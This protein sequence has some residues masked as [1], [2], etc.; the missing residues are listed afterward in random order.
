MVGYVLWGALGTLV[1]LAGSG[2]LVG[3]RLLTAQRRTW[4]RHLTPRL[5]A[6]A[7]YIQSIAPALEAE[8]RRLPNVIV[9]LMDDMG[10]GDIGAFGNRLIKTPRLDE[11]AASGAVMRNGFASSPVCTP[12]RF[13]LLTGRYPH[14]GM[15]NGVFFPSIK[16]R[17]RDHFP[18]G[19]DN[20]G[21][22]AGL[23]SPPKAKNPM[24]AVIRSLIK[25]T[26]TVNA[27]LPDEITLAEALR[28]RGYRTGIFGKW[29]LGDTPGSVPNDKG[30]DYFF[31][32]HYSNDMVPYH[33]WRN[34]TVVEG[35][36]IDQS[37]LTRRLTAEITEFIDRSGDD[38]FFVYYPSPWPHH[39][40]HAGSDFKGRSNAGLYGD[41]IEEIDWSVGTIVDALKDRGKLENT[42]I[43]FTSDNGPWH[44]GSPGGHRGRKGNAFNGGVA[45]PTIAS[46]PSTIPAGRSSDE[47]VMNIDILPTLLA[48]AGID[49]PQDREID[50]RDI[51]PLLVGERTESPHDEL[52]F[53]MDM[54]AQAV[55]DRDRFKY[56]GSGKSDN[57]TYGMLKIHPFLF[58][59]SRDR[60]ESY[61]LKAHHPDRAAHM[62]DRLARFNREIRSNPRGWKP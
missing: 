45:V 27:M 30:F 13:G 36:A 58:D 53:V 41:C 35:G 42:L 22:V 51:L 47:I 14:R 19:Y 16:A 52:F 11:L 37:T 62:R 56:Y 8:K 55:V 20:D 4:K 23:D 34:K 38:P 60:D 6:H 5:A 54:K 21:A 12:S 10:W 49:L 59:T 9:I 24:S 40:L 33:I 28:A 17:K 43:V 7:R 44:Q 29:H 3:R 57:S 31:G 50:G 18:V 26:L 48:A 25:S 32:A 2:I 61:D 1:V 39:P 15:I 46:W